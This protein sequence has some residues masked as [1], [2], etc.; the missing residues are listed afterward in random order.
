MLGLRNLYCQLRE[1][2]YY[3]IPGSVK[4]F[5]K[6]ERGHPDRGREMREGG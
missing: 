6:F 5:Q 3:P 1:R 4:V 2:D